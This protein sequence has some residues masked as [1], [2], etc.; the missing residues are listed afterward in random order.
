M[1]QQLSPCQGSVSGNYPEPSSGWVLTMIYMI[2]V[3]SLVPLA[4][5]AYIITE[6]LEP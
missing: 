3:L 2:L 5:L 6:S 1:L 4:A